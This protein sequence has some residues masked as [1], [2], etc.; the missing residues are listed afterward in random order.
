MK[1]F[2]QSL[3]ALTLGASLTALAEDPK[4]SDKAVDPTKPAVTEQAKPDTKSKKTDSSH[5]QANSTSHTS[6]SKKN[7]NAKQK[8]QQ[9]KHTK[10]P[11]TASSVPTKPETKRVDPFSTVPETKAVD[12]TTAAKPTPK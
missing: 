10:H 12:P 6:K 7:K 9:A 3:A 11:P 2:I 8:H 1:R 5:H 4:N